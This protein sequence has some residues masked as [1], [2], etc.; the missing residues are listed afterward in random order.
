MFVEQFTAEAIGANIYVQ[1]K[2]YYRE[3]FD[4]NG[5][6]IATHQDDLPPL[7][8]YG[9]CRLPPPVIISYASRLLLP[10]GQKEDEDRVEGEQ[11][12]GADHRPLGCTNVFC[13]QQ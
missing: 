13:K 6:S 8:I 5:S 12:Q 3:A 1:P 10:S 7:P 9:F 11:N 2:V 4:E